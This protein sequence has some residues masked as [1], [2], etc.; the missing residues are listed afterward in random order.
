MD[1]IK[2]L[3]RMHE[4]EGC[5]IREI[6]RRTGYHYQTIRKYLN[7][8]NFNKPIQV[9][10]K[11]ASLLDPLKP[12]IDEWLKEDRKVP[13]KQRHTAKRVYERLQEEYSDE[14]AVKYRTVVSYVSQKKRELNTDHQKSYLPLVHKAGEAQ[15]DFGQ[16]VYYDQ[17][18]IMQNGMKLT[19][20]FPY[21]NAAYCQIFH[22][23]NQECLLQGIRNIIEHMGAV[24]YRMVFDNL[25]AAVVQ[26]GKGHERILSEPFSRF[27][28]HYGIE[29]FFCNPA[30][31]WEKGNVENKVGYERRSMFVPVPTI[32]DFNRFNK[33]LFQCSEEDHQR[34][35]YIKGE[36]IQ[37]LFEEDKTAML[38]LNPVPYE[39]YR[40]ESRIADKYGKVMFD[41]NRYSSSPKMAKQTVYVKA[42][43]DQVFL[44]DEQ[45]Q[46]IT[47]HERL[48]GKG[49]ESMNWL[50][51]LELMSKR[52]TA[53]KYTGFYEQL[54]D[55]W[56]NYLD[57][58]GTNQKREIL[59][60]LQIMLQEHDMKT[61]T[62]ALEMALS[63][64]VRDAESI[65]TTYHRLVQ[66]LQWMQ[67][68]QLPSDI[69]QMPSF[70]TD[71]K[72]YDCFFNKKKVI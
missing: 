46:V 26:M 38:R 14:L 66:P 71:N 21:S 63:N 33:Q 61:A 35:H 49:Q 3:R 43:S 70:Q 1:E 22:G 24:P 27:M 2:Y 68:M 45:Y 62:D 25:S 69:T 11:R 60:K 37:S 16:F 42:T 44:L 6:M 18:E 47:E 65:L 28:T 15:I 48:Y 57:E 8:D 30:S 53:I 12:I 4:R 55:I 40:F 67:P 36:K 41:D 52:P 7:K 13:R 5:S 20:S 64:G 10:A 9:P 39:I 59:L 51:Y 50:P 54:P 58:L 31:G 17:F 56:K 32:S 23:E 34:N 19:M 29:A 72:H